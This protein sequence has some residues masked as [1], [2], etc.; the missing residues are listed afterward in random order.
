VSKK[1]NRLAIRPCRISSAKQPIRVQ[2]APQRYCEALYID[3]SFNNRHVANAVTFYINHKV[4]ELARLKQYKSELQDNVRCYIQAKA[5]GT[6]LWVSLVCRQLAETS[7]RK[8]LSVLQ[9]FPPGLRPFY[10]MMMEQMQDMKDKEDF[11]ICKQILAAVVLAYRPTNSSQRAQLNCQP[12]RRVIR[13]HSVFGRARG[14]MWFIS[15]HS[16]GLH[17]CCPSVSQGVPQYPCRVEHLS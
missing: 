17:L 1:C 2:T 14:T 6:F 8:T 3:Y 12:S 15:D 10:Q 5:G 11:E 13:R 9:T 16:R 7:L 4:E